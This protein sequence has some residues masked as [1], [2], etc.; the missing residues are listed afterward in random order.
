MVKQA[1]TLAERLTSCAANDRERIDRAYRLMY[2][3][4][5]TEPEARLAGVS[6]P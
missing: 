2:G 3:R 6:R 4:S 1:D 5:V